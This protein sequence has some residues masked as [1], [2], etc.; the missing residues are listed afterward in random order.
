MN[1][2]VYGAG[3]LGSLYA[4]NL[5][6]AG[7]RVTVLARGK[8]LEEL[9][10]NGII[11]LDEAT[12]EQTATRVEVIGNLEPDRAFDLV[13]VI[14][15]K[16]Q[17]SS[18]LPSLANNHFTPN[19]LFMVNNAA[20]PAELTAALGRHRVLL[21]FA[22]AG[23]AYIDGVVRYRITAIQKTTIGEL[24]GANS[25]RIHQISWI[26]QEAGFPTEI[27]SDMDAWLKTHVAMVSPVANAIYM[28]GGDTYRLSRT[29]DALVLMV[30]AIREGLR[31]LRSLGYPITPFYYGS[32]DC[33][34]E[35][36]LVFVL[37]KGMASEAAQ[38]V[39]A[40]HANAA[41]DEMQVVAYEFK[42]LAAQS[43]LATPAIDRLAAYINPETHPVEDGQSSLPLNWR[44]T[45]AAAGLLTAVG[46]TFGWLLSRTKR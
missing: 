9:R 42:Q 33:I 8:R 1:V 12:G 22:G 21:G 4:A 11:L 18:V 29:R 46:I 24:D 36:L 25:Q 14:V 44:K 6:R 5:Q 26:L 37:K 34:P 15:R 10:E 28:A 20:G 17:L 31:V 39:L 16:N 30:R 35:P 7:Q 45:I 43:G 13:L 32:L 38:L 2:L 23:G 19:V 40:R 3:V 41:R 27:C